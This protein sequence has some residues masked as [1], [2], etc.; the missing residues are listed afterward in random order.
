MDAWLKQSS[1][2]NATMKKPTNSLNY[3]KFDK[4]VDSDDEEEEK[5]RRRQA[6]RAVQP[7]SPGDVP[8]HLRAAYARVT[9]A[10]ERG[11]TK[12]LRAAMLELEQQLQA[13]RMSSRSSSSP[14][15]TRSSSRSYARRRPVS[16]RRRVRARLP[17]HERRGRGARRH[18]RAAEAAREGAE[19]HRRARRT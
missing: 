15:W 1:N 12:E 17:Q 19:C 13:C 16:A 5:Q 3:S 18:R 2:A 8:P 11:D 4:I 6:R 14:P 10:Q 9:I 7:R